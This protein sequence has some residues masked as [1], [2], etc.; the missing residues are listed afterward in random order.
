MNDTPLIVYVLAIAVPAWI[1]GILVDRAA[2]RRTKD[3][4]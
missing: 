3:D 1:L 2:A 4:R